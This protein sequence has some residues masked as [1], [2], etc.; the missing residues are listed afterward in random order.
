LSFLA[1][2]R[3]RTLR[4]SRCFWVGSARFPQRGRRRRLPCRSDG[5]IDR[6]RGRSRGIEPGVIVGAAGGD[7]AVSGASGVA[8]VG[9]AVV[10]GA[11]VVAASGRALVP[12]VGAAGGVAVA[13][14]A[15]VAVASGVEL[16]PS[17]IVV[18]AGG[19]AMAPGARAKSTAGWRP[20]SPH[21]P[22]Y[23][24]RGHCRKSASMPTHWKHV[25][26]LGMRAVQVSRAA[27]PWRAAWC[28]R[29]PSA[30]RTPR[31]EP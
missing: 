12:S 23:L 5:V 30:S 6:S 8:V 10:P 11:I 15:I 26:S 1:H 2:L 29:V 31:P 28:S 27:A 13:S 3:E 14:G 22:W 17:V 24:R 4:P 16:V 25:Q 21:A 9:V 7:E 20:H 19:V 18:A